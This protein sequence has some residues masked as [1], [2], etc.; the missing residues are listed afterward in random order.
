[1]RNRVNFIEG[2]YFVCCGFGYLGIKYN[3]F[4]FLNKFGMNQVFLFYEKRNLERMLLDIF[5][6]S[7]LVGKVYLV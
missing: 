2:V 3:C 4:G 7:L 1:M 6:Y 5:F